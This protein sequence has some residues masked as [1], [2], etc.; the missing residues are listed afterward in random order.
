MK[1]VFRVSLHICLLDFIL[2]FLLFFDWR[3]S[4]TTLN[5]QSPLHNL[6]RPTVPYHAFDHVTHFAQ[7][8][9]FAKKPSAYFLQGSLLYPYEPILWNCRIVEKIDIKQPNNI[10]LYSAT[11]FPTIV[12]YY[13]FPKSSN[14]GHSS[15]LRLTKWYF[16]VTGKKSVIKVVTSYFIFVAESM[17]QIV[18][19]CYFICRLPVNFYRH[20]VR[21]SSKYATWFTTAFTSP[22]G[23]SALRP[24]SCFSVQQHLR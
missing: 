2:L 20:P 3:I 17:R 5:V 21:I 7:F 11:N 19:L 22:S 8:A 12:K 13:F 10:Q 1:R 23:E 4:P 24:N 18:C 15:S 6:G 14:S 16:K 9:K